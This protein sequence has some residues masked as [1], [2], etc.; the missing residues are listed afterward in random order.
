MEI[1][2]PPYT[3]TDKMLNLVAGIMENLG[4]MVRQYMM[5]MLKF[6]WHLLI[7]WFRF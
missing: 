5:E 6:L 3:I 1:N 7:Q 2:Y 4:I